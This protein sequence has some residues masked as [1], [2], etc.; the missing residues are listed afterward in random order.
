MIMTCKSSH[1]TNRQINKLLSHTTNSN[2][3]SFSGKFGG[4][5]L[6]FNQIFLPKCNPFKESTIS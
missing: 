2:Q 1:L 4:K 5:I 6:E 3:K